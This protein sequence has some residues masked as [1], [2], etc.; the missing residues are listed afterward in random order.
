MLA[1]WTCPR[2]AT[3]SSLREK[4]KVIKLIR[5]EEKY[6]AE[7]AQIYGKTNLLFVKL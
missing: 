1:T 5:K 6:F 4:V 7:I 3:Q 2:E